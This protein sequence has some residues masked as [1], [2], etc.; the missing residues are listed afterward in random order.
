M[1]TKNAPLRATLLL[2]LAVFC[3]VYGQIRSATITGSVKDGT[4]AVVANAAVSI[5]NQE[6][7]ISA[8]ANATDSGQFT[9]PYLPAGSYTITVSAPGFVI[10]KE[11]GVKLSTAQTVRVDAVLKLSTV[12]TT[13]E[14]QAQAATIQT[15]STS[16]TG[17]LQAR[18]HRRDPQRHAKSAVLRLP[19]ER[20]AAPQ[21]GHRYHR[22]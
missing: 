20:R 7:N 1:S 10:F 9:F 11:S 13:V 12:E 8:S 21:C 6:T 3:Q 16:V 14:V 19:A 18:G 15:D 17:A 2:H 4:G 22:R 5:V